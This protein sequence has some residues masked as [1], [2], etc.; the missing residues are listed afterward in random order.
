MSLMIVKA[1]MSQFVFFL[2][3][4]TQCSQRHTLEHMGSRRD[5]GDMSKESRVPQIHYTKQTKCEQN[6][7]KRQTILH[8][9]DIIAVNGHIPNTGVNKYIKQT[10]RELKGEIGSNIVI[11]NSSPP[12]STVDRTTRPKVNVKTKNLKHKT[13]LADI[14]RRHI[15]SSAQKT[16]FDTNQLLTHEISLNKLK[17]IEDVHPLCL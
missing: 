12:C 3:P 7:D 6:C 16:F 11:R 17:K 2:N 14:Y 5:G 4:T 1:Y 9:E 8:Q 13:N 10:S 15:F